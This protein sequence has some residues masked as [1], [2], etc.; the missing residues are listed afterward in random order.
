MKE[1]FNKF[2]KSL[3]YME[4]QTDNRHFSIRKAQVS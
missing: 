4:G 3:Q 2:M 1:L